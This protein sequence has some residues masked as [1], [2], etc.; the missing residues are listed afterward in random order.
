LLSNKYFA[1]KPPPQPSPARG[2]GNII[3]S[4]L[5]IGE[6]GFGQL[7]RNSIFFL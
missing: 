1:E 7:S 3:Y 6:K 2:R 5:P 4:L